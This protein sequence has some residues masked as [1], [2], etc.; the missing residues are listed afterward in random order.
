MY[1]PTSGGAGRDGGRCWPLGPLMVQPSIGVC[2]MLEVS[3]S[4]CWVA[5]SVWYA[6][7]A[8]AGCGSNRCSHPVGGV[9]GGGGSRV[10]ISRG[11][12]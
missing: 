5:S 6:V 11:T 12:W 10:V 7:I 2:H 1:G 4:A 9:E 8:S 3:R